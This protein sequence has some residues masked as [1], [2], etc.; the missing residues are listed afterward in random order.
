MENTNTSIYTKLFEFQKEIQSLPKTAKNPFFKS[1]Y[2]PLESIVSE[3]NPI[4]HKHGLGITF[5][6]DNQ[7]KVILRL[8]SLDGDYLESSLELIPKDLT[9]Q[10]YGSSITYARRYLLMSILNLVG[11]KDDDGNIASAKQTA[12]KVTQ[13]KESYIN[14]SQINLMFAKQKEFGLSLDDLKAILKNKFDVESSRN[15][16]SK[17]FNKVLESLIN[18]KNT[19]VA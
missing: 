19:G 9:P 12:N 4:L 6:N 17:D 5:L 18:F 7:C 8:Y 15:I 3:A 16:L 2:V 11:E 14:Q 10:G 13:T 1:E